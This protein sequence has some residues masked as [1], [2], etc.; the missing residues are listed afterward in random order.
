MSTTDS[1]V[2]QSL[3]ELS[4]LENERIAEEHAE[5][6][7]RARAEAEAKARA[8]AEAEAKEAH[9]RRVAEAEAALRL[10]EERAE[11]N[12]EA[13]KRLASLRAELAAVQADRERMHTRIATI[14]DDEWTSRPPREGSWGWKVAF[15]SAGAVAAGLALILAVREPVQPTRIVQVPVERTVVVERAVAE[16]PTDAP[17]VEPTEP[18][19]ARTDE[20]SDVAGPH[21]RRPHPGMRPHAQNTTTQLLADLDCA[22]DDPTCGI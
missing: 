3:R 11:R 2:I 14:A 17:V 22:E 6:E 15:A 16:E 10:S 20:P 18:A 4:R 19:I 21:V 5:A 7:A 8:V 1:S 9:A 13:D 12:A